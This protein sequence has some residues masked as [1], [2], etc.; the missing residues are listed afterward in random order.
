MVKLSKM[1][2]QNLFIG[3]LSL[4]FVN[5]P[6]SYAQLKVW[7]NTNQT[8]NG[9][10]VVGD[11]T[12]PWD[13]YLYVKNTTANKRC[14]FLKHYATATSG[15]HSSGVQVDQAGTASWVVFDSQGTAK[16]WVMGN[17]DAYTRSTL[18]SSDSTLKKDIS[19]MKS[20]KEGLLSL[21]GYKYIFKDDLSSQGKKSIGFLAQEVAKVFPEVVNTED[22]KMFIAY[23]SIIP[24]VV[25]AMKEQESEIREM[26][27][28]I[29]SLSLKI[30][31]LEKKLEKGSPSFSGSINSSSLDDSQDLGQEAVLY[32]NSPNPFTK[33]TIIRSFLP[34]SVKA[35]SLS[36]FNGR[37]VEM[38]RIVLL[39]RGSI[40]TLLDART[41]KPGTYF[42]NL[43]VD[44]KS[45]SSK[46]M[47][48]T[49]N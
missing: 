31:E 42:Y 11:A 37:G 15:Q 26:K 23:Y 46:T 28:D 38:K 8:V 36:V 12:S 19:R 10:V 4:I 29:E 27:S 49:A 39:E 5:I 25:E 2:T 48:I 30:V 20:V 17:G 33:T 34:N 47:I 18:L 40:E 9:Q 7:N 45:V 32:Q 6:N 24:I 14:L 21:N 35:A 43:I 16:F 13:A 22:G 1:K 44:N 41:L 3:M